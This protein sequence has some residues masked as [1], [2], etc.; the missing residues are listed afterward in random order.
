MYSGKI[1][2]P[3]VKSLENNSKLI[4]SHIFSRFYVEE[5]RIQPRLRILA[6]IES[7]VVTQRRLHD[8]ELLELVLLPLF[9]NLHMEHE[10]SVREKAVDLIISLCR[11]CNSKHCTGLL[12]VL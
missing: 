11:H 6:M 12:D 10:V 9:Q 3:T 7:T 2:I 8:E 5:K 1:P 4:H